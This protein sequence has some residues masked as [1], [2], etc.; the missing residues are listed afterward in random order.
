MLTHKRLNEVISTDTY[1]ANVNSIEGY[2]SAQGFFGMT[3]KM[4]YFA[5]M[6]LNR[7]LL[8][9]ISILLENVILHLN[10]EEIMRNLR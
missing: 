6:K 9:Y 3:S 4:L 1:F 7:S 8:T 10:S 2:H 5:G